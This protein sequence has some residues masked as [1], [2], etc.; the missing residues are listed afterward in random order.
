[1]KHCDA[2]QKHFVYAPFNL[3]RPPGVLPL[4]PSSAPVLSRSPGNFGESE[5]ASQGQKEE[6]EE[7]ESTL[8]PHAPKGGGRRGKGGN[9]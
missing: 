7:A 4:S 2:T 8:A 3:T 1:M 6:E 9:S 5:R